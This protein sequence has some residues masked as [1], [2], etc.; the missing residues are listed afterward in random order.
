[1]RGGEGIGQGGDMGRDGH[2]GVPPK[3]VFGWQRLLI[4][5][6]QRRPAE[7]PGIERRDK[8]VVHQLGARA[9]S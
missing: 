8:I 3:G 2:L 4:E 9:R 6:I 5:D 7:V 1:M